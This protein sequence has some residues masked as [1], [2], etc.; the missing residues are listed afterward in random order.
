MAKRCSLP[1][2]AAAGP[3]PAAGLFEPIVTTDELLEAT[4]P[5]AWVRAMLDAEAALAAA[6]ADAGLIP[7]E[8]ADR[9][10]ASCAGGRFDPGALGRAAR[11]GGNPV[12]PLVAALTEAAGDAGGW[13]HWGATSQDILDTA[14]MLVA[15]RAL[16]CIEPSLAALAD[17]CAA[18]ASAHRATL[19]AGRTLLQ[20]AVPTTFGLRAAG[21]LVATGEAA[22]RIRGARG[23]LAAQLGGA[24]GT[25]AALGAAGPDVVARFAARLQLAEPVMPWHTDRTRVVELGC[26]LAEAAGVAAKIALDVALLMQTEVAEAFEPAAPGRGGSSTMPQKRNPVGAAAVGAA[27]RRAHALVPVLLGALVAEHDRA[28]GGWQAE[29]ETLSELLRLCGGAVARAADTV[30]G[31]EVRPDRMRDNVGLTDGLLLAERV[32]V[33]LAGSMGRPAAR[34]LV[35]EAARRAGEDGGGFAGALL[36]EPQ[37][38]AVLGPGELDRLLDPAGYLGA[39]GVFV[40]R[41]LAAHRERRAAP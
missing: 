37:V 33:A 20:H 31:L 14:A 30:T 23:R 18:Q 4:G 13:V 9:I 27:A 26:A 21:W 35:E 7:R 40:D 29:W 5:D 2:D 22:D 3:S 24:S 12:M 6:E 17:G 8:A 10:A 28:V 39:A 19:M 25:L 11:G 32:T 1:G 41:A 34:R 16:A 38:A 15:R 36:A